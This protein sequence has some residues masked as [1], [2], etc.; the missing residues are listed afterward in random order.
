M[1]LALL[2]F[3]LPQAV[4]AQSADDGFNPGADNSVYCMAVQA[5][6]KVLVGGDFTTL[7]GQARSYLGRLN[8][9]GSLDAT[10]TNGADFTVYAL[11]VQGD[12]K[13]LVG[14]NF[15]TLAGQPRSYLGRLNA[16]GSLDAT[17]TNGTDYAVNA[18]AV[19]PDG[20]I[21]VG[22][23][24]WTLAG[25][26][27]AYLG[28]LH[29]D[30]S[31][32]AAFN[33]GP[34]YSV[35]A[36]AIQPDGK[37]VV[38]GNFTML[39]GQDR[40]Y[41]GR[42]HA[43]GSLDAGFTNGADGVVSA[44]AVQEDG[45]ILVGGA[46]T[47][48]GGEVREYLGRLDPDGF[49]DSGFTGGTDGQVYALA[50]Q[51]DGK[52]LVGGSFSTL[53]GSARDNLGRLNADGT[54]DAA[55]APGADY[56]VFCLLPQCD[57][58]VLAGG[59]FATLGG[60]TR[61]C[62][63]RVNADGSADTTLTN[64]AS[65]AVYALPA[66]PDG[67]VVVGGLFTNLGGQARSRLARLNA[68]GSLDASFAAA[69]GSNV[70]AAGL[71]AD[72][73]ILV[74]GNFTNLSG[75]A[76]ARLGR[77]NV[78]GSLDATLASGA[79]GDVLSLVAQ[80]NGQ[81]LVAGAFTNLGG[82]GRGYLGRLNA[83]GSVD[84]AFTS[85]ANACVYAVVPQTNGQIL[86]GGL[87]TALAGQTR[88]GLGRLNADGSLDTTFT[89][90]AVSNVYALA[91][92]ADGKI[93]VGGAFTNLAGQARARL[94]RL[95]ADGS[96][97]TTFT[98]GAN[99]AVYTLALQA[100]GR[101][102][103]GGAFTTLAG[104]SRGYLGR[105]NAN[106]SLDGT[107]TN[108]ANGEVYSLSVLTDGKIMAGGLF[109][110]LG[111]LARSRL[112]RLSTR[113]AAIQNLSATPDT[114]LWERSG[115]APEV[116][117]TT[118]ERSSDGV[119]WLDLGA[120]ARAAGGW[121]RT[122][123][124]LPVG[125]NFYLRARG[126]ARSGCYDAD[127]SIVE[128]VRL[129]H[130]SPSMLILATNGAVVFSGAAASA[131]RDTAFGCLSVGKEVTRAFVITNRGDAELHIGGWV[132]NGAGAAEF[133]ISGLPSAIAPGASARFEVTFSPGSGGDHNASVG[134]ANDSMS[135][136]YV[137][138]VSGRAYRLSPDS[139]PYFGGNAVTIS[140]WTFGSGT[141]ITNVMAGGLAATILE[142][143]A[144]WVRVGMPA[145]APP[146]PS[147]VFIGTNSHTRGNWK[148]VVG[149]DGY[150]V[151][152]HS[153]ST[154]SYAEVSP[155]GQDLL[156]WAASTNDGRA[157][158]KANS[159]TDRV[160]ACWC[161]GTNFTVDVNLTDGSAHR[162]AL[163]CVD[164]DSASRT[165]RVDL[166]DATSGTVLDSRTVRSFHGGAY[167]VWDV[168]G[169]VVVRLTAIGGSAVLSGLFFDL[170]EDRANLVA[171]GGFESGTLSNWPVAANDTLEVFVQ[172]NLAEQGTCALEMRGSW[173][174]WSWNE[175][176]QRLRLQSG[177][178]MRASAR[179]NVAK[180][181]REGGSFAVAGIKLHGASQIESTLSSTI[182]NT[183]WRDLGFTL[184]LTYSGSYVY[185]CMVCGSGTAEAEVYFDE[186]R[187]WKEWTRAEIPTDAS[188]VFVGSNR[189]AR[190]TWKGVYGRDGYQVV[191]NAT[192]YPAYAQ[193]APSGHTAY[194][195]AASTT[196]PRALQKA[197]SGST[198]RIAACW[199]SGTNFTVDVNLTDGA[200]HQ[201]AVYCVDMDRLGRTQRVDVVDGDSG[202]VLSSHA[203]E[204]FTNGVY[205]A[206][207]V[208]GHV[209]L[210]VTYTGTGGYN[211]VVSGLFFDPVVAGPL[212]APVVRMNAGGVMG[213]PFSPSGRAY[214]LT[215]SGTSS[216]T[217]AAAWSSNW[218]GLS[219]TGGVLAAGGSTG[220]TV[221]IGDAARELVEGDYSD[222]VVF[223]NLTTGGASLL[224]VNLGVRN[225]PGR[226]DIVLQSASL[227]D[228]A[229]RG[230]VYEY[231]PPLVL[232]IQSRY[233]IGS[234][235]AGVHTN[236]RGA[237]LTNTM[238]ASAAQGETQ[239]V[240]AGWTLTGHDPASGVST[241]LVMTVSN[242][243]T[244]TWLWTTNYRLTAAADGQ[245]GVAPGT[246][247]HAA[248][249][250]VTLV[251]AAGPYCLF[252][253]WTGDVSGGS[254][255]ANP[256]A[257]LMSGPKSVVA[258][259]REELAT[260]STPKWWL[261]QHYPGTSDFNNA[262]A[263]DTDGD[264]LR[265]W[266]EYVALT[267]P[268][269]A[270]SAFLAERG[271]S[272]GT[273]Y[274]ISWPSASNRHYS[275]YRGTNL[276]TAFAPLATNLDGT[277][278][279]NSYTDRTYGAGAPVFYRIKVRK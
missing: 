24:F 165:Q 25:A 9:D 276:S 186:V 184:P 206:W 99:G 214:S 96:L 121:E 94:G 235:P 52:V 166:L 159:S 162:L 13:I 115:A 240:C 174:A 48:L 228:T 59:W 277:P 273:N 104:Q 149:A 253:N 107:F 231:M 5:D 236:W 55:F 111:G 118:F 56:F 197:A 58:K 245:G 163:Y 238:G 172:S 60:Q 156:V 279:E 26:D 79:S 72:G 81:I 34:D 23:E 275:V 108:Q 3:F 222:T 259:F 131:A 19:Q 16:D 237:I 260:N 75:Q 21:L 158:Q 88:R 269:N 50:L 129:A 44:L 69:A 54:L 90:G 15:T 132:T 164:W 256:V 84:A 110:T 63:G 263:S 45:G 252:T 208:R 33:A 144:D 109:T 102:L 232:T 28:R 205:L 98:N 216:F 199:R 30:G 73:R 41:L 170:P 229:L 1:S 2:A 220:V 247:W 198:D 57:G 114:V 62:L 113:T 7:G 224:G 161:S 274:V 246:G 182:S 112:G 254:V 76:R 202:A 242:H 147:A 267:Q 241:Q 17:F 195:W 32:D 136:A 106:G 268:T 74:G 67:K 218:I 29:A 150:H 92:Q 85:A 155:A 264:G 190:G 71:Q 65:G 126:F 258:H 135:G 230:G 77:L 101:I 210:Q 130:L 191:N 91:V 193:A 173:S 188:A 36:L 244:L 261:A 187:L 183:G 31:L 120:G 117:R 100:D 160:A 18:L 11:A 234:P 8:P 141:D 250:N 4:G 248:G 152:N 157:L 189:T 169:H 148:G 265:A 225:P 175:R 38:G 20:K 103:V 215:N 128:C 47:T 40:A 49:T 51:P 167:L 83:D 251:A 68:D 211:A 171:D 227:G 270:G 143:G 178:V 219:A 179:I 6:G 192:S 151:I 249:S 194:T 203:L 66:Q 125:T 142:Q 61:S 255:T 82:Q 200:T 278:P 217:W 239:Y 70:Y 139:G 262:E 37:I 78:D 180:L 154:P 133:R 123:L 140:G 127:D 12:G 223:T 196:D 207:N 14:G 95:N 177:D 168:R 146:P 122:G 272:A 39:G 22:G 212:A 116:W 185:R 35:Y 89:N 233:G 10:F 266:Q 64:G 137:V 204:N 53:A 27:R 257:V 105:L 87:F 134:I 46:F 181:T 119:T 221:S 213:G 226:V 42:L 153:T 176:G 209:A 138:N 271:E 86:V 201:V 93:L 124:D 145:Y 80:T 43:D 243:A 97:D